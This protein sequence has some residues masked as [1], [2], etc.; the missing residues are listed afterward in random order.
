M[1]QVNPTQPQKQAP[2]T[3]WGVIIRQLTEPSAQ[4]SEVG[5]RQKAQ[6]ASGLIILMGI[7]SLVGAIAGREES[8]P[9]QFLSLVFI[10]IAYFFSRTRYHAFGTFLFLLS[11]SASPFIAILTRAD[12]EIQALIYSWLPLALIIASA[13]INR[14]ALFLLTGLLVGAILSLSIIYTGD[15]FPL[16]ARQI[17]STSGI[18]TIIGLLL[19]YME[20][21]RGNIEKLR[22]GELRKINEELSQISQFLEERVTE[23]TAQLDRKTSQ[24]EASAM[25]ARSAAETTDIREL[26]ET[27]VNQISNRFG[28]YHTGIFLSDTSRQKVYLAAASSEGGKRLLSHGH[29][30]N[31]GREGVVGYAAYEKRPRVAQDI[32]R[33]SVYFRNPELPDT[34]SEAALPLLIKNQ[35]IGV[36]DIQSTEGNPFGAE[37]LFILQTMADQIALAIQNA[38][39]LEESRSAL[40]ELK[41]I[42]NQ[43][44]QDA[45]RGYLGQQSQGYVYNAGSVVPINESK[46]A[47]NDEESR[48][49][50]VGIVLRGQRIGVINLKRNTSQTD[51]TDK[52]QDF[53]EKIATQLALAIE[54]ARLLEESQRRAAREQTLNELTTRLSRSLDLETL[55]QNA[56][57]ELHKL[58]QVT[59][60]SVMITPQEIRKQA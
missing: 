43:T 33:E 26:L 7:G 4:I 5:E 42:S 49:L 10:V 36:L 23:R 60:A 11:I 18:I 28:F 6:I 22:L 54:N 45:W 3:P 56:V 57:L 13:L 37:D 47:L 44:V 32:D 21:V 58:P 40:N 25:V 48:M 51:W 59:D 30:L 46:A 41:G 2:E 27:V 16:Q 31:I 53:T 38:R 14:W 12:G 20:T 17:A 55:L 1:N 24:L 15:Q 35:V 19:I 52:E 50:E 39:L 29:S 8:R 34:R 9:Y